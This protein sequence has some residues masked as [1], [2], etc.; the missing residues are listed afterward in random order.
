MKK[1]VILMI[2]ILMAGAL[3]AVVLLCEPLE[4]QQDEI[5]RLWNKIDEL[6]RRLELLESPAKERIDPGVTQNPQSPAWENK[7]NWRRLRQG[8]TEAQV[9]AILGEPIKVI[10]GAKT[11][12]YYPNIYCGYVTFNEDGSLS[13]WNEP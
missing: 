7:K 3:A 2:T 8:M 13:Q 1:S 6:E 4:A 5:S 12:W 11:L 9:A 10:Q